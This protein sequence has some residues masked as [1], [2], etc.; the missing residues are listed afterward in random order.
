MKFI[1][2]GKNYQEHAWEMDG[3]PTPE[4]V[5]FLKPDTAW[6]N[7]E[8]ALYI[9]EFTQNLHYETEILV[10]ICKNGKHIQPEFAHNYYQEIGLGIDFTARD[11]QLKLKQNGLPWE[12]SKAF[13]GSAVVGKFFSKDT[14]ENVNSLSFELYKNKER[15]QKGNSEQMIWSIEELICQISK[16]FTLRQGDIIFTG[17]PQGV[18]KVSAGDTLEGFLAGEASFRVEIK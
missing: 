10:K 15:V 18:G 13:D 9:P 1:C 5:I 14:F 7:P 12:T 2:I 17:T 8:Q 4:P 16:F 11:L 6:H 3:K